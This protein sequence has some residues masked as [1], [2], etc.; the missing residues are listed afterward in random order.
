MTSGGRHGT[1]HA[2]ASVQA[3]VSLF[4]RVRTSI[5]ITRNTTLIDV[6]HP[7][8]RT[9]WHIDPSSHLATTDMDRKLGG[10][11]CPFE[12]QGAGSPPNTMWPG[13]RPTACQVSYWPTQPFGHS[14][15]TLQTDSQDRQ[16]SDSIRRTVLQTVAQKPLEKP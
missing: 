16:R 5:T 7:Y 8:L 1:L 2:T 13:P 3:R 10:G 12:G 9:R 4:A 15:P 11:L 14:T 6:R